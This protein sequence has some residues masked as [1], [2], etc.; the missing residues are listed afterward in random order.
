MIDEWTTKVRMLP[1][2]TQTS[3]A[4]RSGQKSAVNAVAEAKAARR[5]ARLLWRDLT[6]QQRYVY[7]TRGHLVPEWIELPALRCGDVDLLRQD[8]DREED[9]PFRES[10]HG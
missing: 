9:W 2:S 6:P 5:F 8:P 10:F 4:S 7:R 3:T 1:A